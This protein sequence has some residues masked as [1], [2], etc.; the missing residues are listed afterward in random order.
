MRINF[1]SGKEL[2]VRVGWQDDG[3]V[4]WN[5]RRREVFEIADDEQLIGCELAHSNIYFEGVTW[6]KMKTKF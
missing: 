2:L 4:D 6:L 1:Y 5:G 3:Y